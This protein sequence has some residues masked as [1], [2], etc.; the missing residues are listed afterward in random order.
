V[1]EAIVFLQIVLVPQLVFSIS[2]AVDQ[3]RLTYL[4]ETWQRART[5]TKSLSVEFN[6]ERQDNVFRG[7]SVAPGVFKLRRLA[8][9]TIQARCAIKPKQRPGVKVKGKEDPFIGLLLGKQIYCLNAPDKGIVKLDLGSGDPL[10]FLEKWFLPLLVLLDRDGLRKD[11]EVK[12][13][14]Q[15]QSYSYVEIRPKKGRHFSWFWDELV[16]GH[17]A[18]MNKNGVDVPADM[19]KALLWYS[20]SGASGTKIDILKWQTNVPGTVTDRD[21]ELPAWEVVEWPVVH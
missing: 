17:A 15:D 6:V 1:Q 2:L 21:F 14:R 5:E 16:T 13:S 4:L 3:V 11:F 12:V 18:F 19:P 8:N 9:G 7:K 10:K 20:I